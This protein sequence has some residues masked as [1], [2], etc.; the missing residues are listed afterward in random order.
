[1]NPHYVIMEANNNHSAYTG[2]YHGH[3]VQG[4]PI[5]HSQPP[6]PFLSLPPPIHHHQHQHQ[7]H[8][9][10]HQQMMVIHPLHP[11]HQPIFRKTPPFC[12]RCGKF[13]DHGICKEICNVLGFEIK[14]SMC[15]SCGY[16]GHLSKNC[17][18]KV[19]RNFC[20][21]CSGF[22]HSL[23]ECV[24]EKSVYG[25]DLL[26][27]K[28]CIRCNYFGHTK[29]KCKEERTSSGELIVKSV[30]AEK[31]MKMA[32]NRSII[33]DIGE[34]ENGWYD[35]IIGRAERSGNN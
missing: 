25:D 4:H 1:M 32:N 22:G 12:E 34:W 14:R 31:K 18:V 33:D 8:Q 16:H 23:K 19:R 24:A 28:R 26:C 29:D 3:P 20:K 5:Q 13:G 15:S 21:K 11:H 2:P 9:Q 7:H 6:P 17:D 10:H 35:M 27:P 30:G